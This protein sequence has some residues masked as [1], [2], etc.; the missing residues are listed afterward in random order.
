M[1]TRVLVLAALAGT[2]ASV[3]APALA[4]GSLSPHTKIVPGLGP[5]DFGAASANPSPRVTSV[6]P[7]GAGVDGPNPAP[8]QAL[9]TVV[10]ANHGLGIRPGNVVQAW[11]SNSEGQTNVPAGL[12]NVVGVTSGQNHSYAQRADGSLVG[13][14]STI[15]RQTLTPANLG[16]VQALETAADTNLALLPNQTVRIWGCE[17]CPFDFGTLNLP[18]GLLNVVEVDTEGCLGLVR[19]QSGQVVGWGCSTPSNWPF[20]TVTCG[21]ANPPVLPPDVIQIAA[22]TVHGLALRANGEVIAWGATCPE[23]NYGQATIPPGLGPVVAIAAGAQ[24]SLALRADGTVT[25]WGL[26]FSGQASPPL[27]TNVVAIDAKLN[28]SAAQL[29]D[30]TVVV[31]GQEL[32]GVTAPPTGAF[33]IPSNPCYPNCDGS[34]TSPQLNALDFGCFISRYRAGDTYANCDGSTIAPVLNAVDF[35]CFLQRYVAGCR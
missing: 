24:H 19:L 11:G 33:L 7:M 25:A 16:P 34:T 17:N 15:Y 1:S 13:W 10:I 20:P 4:Q 12:N 32:G 26:N 21:Q 2:V 14:G 3:Q 29:A 5:V 18:P 23:T 31:W 6:P 27:L 22:G 28:V 30:G 8:L 9:R 35:S